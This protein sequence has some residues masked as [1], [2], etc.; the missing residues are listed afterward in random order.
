MMYF[1]I[2]SNYKKER[3]DTECYEDA[4]EWYEN[5]LQYGSDSV[6]LTAICLDD[7]DEK[8]QYPN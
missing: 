5:W 7:I 1:I 4:M 8:I 6:E 2:Y 3:Y